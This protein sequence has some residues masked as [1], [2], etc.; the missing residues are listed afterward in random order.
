MVD[1]GSDYWNPLDR[2]PIETLKV[3]IKDLGTSTG[4]GDVLQGFKSD[5]S[6]GA[7]HVELGFTGMAKGSLGQGNTTPEM[8]GKDKRE[9]IRELSKINEVGVTTHA[10]I[11]IN[12]LSGL[13]T[14]N[15]RFSDT[16]ARET[17]NEIKRT[18]DFSA[19]AAGGGAVV[20]HTGEFPRD[21]GEY[22][23]FGSEEVQ[24][25]E[26]V[27]LVDKKTGEIA[28][29]TMNKGEEIYIPELQENANGDWM[30]V[31]GNVTKDR[32]KAIPKVDEEAQIIFK[33]KTWKNYKDEAPKLR[34]KKPKE[35]GNLTND[36]VAAKAMYLD[37]Q[38]SELE[39]AKPFAYQHY[40][41][42]RRVG[43]QIK[44]LQNLQKRYE[45]AEKGGDIKTI[46]NDFKDVAANLRE[47]YNPQTDEN[48]SEF[49]KKVIN[50]S[51]IEAQV[52]LEGYRGYARQIEQ[53]KQ[54]N[55]RIEPISVEG[56]KRSI[57]NITK[58]ATYAIRK[59]EQMERAGKKIDPIY[60]APENIF[61]ESGYG[62][63]PDELKYL[64]VES[65][66]ELANQLHK[67][68]KGKQEATKIAEE[69]IKAT[70]DI[71]H[72]NV[73]RRFFKEDPNKLPEE[74]DK[75]FNKWL[76]GKVD[77]LNKDKI[78]GHAHISDN[79]GYHD[80]HL[81]PGMGSAPINEFIQK[82]KKAGMTEPMIVEW[83]AQSK[84]Q[85]PYGAMLGSWARLASSPIYRI[86]G[87]Q[88]SWTDVEHS[89]YFGRASSPNFIIGKYGPSKDWNA[90]GWSEASI[91]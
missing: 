22:E 38:I 83:G 57:Q 77:E 32:I 89:G 26:I 44:D 29:P 48:P 85:E 24:K 81:T 63:H 60:I 13:D 51:Q 61:P 88:Q 91:E 6:A 8:F 27:I 58:A 5:L 3:S 10:S 47:K 54:L 43:K 36:E 71:G 17:L 19:E 78:I 1:F 59:E 53:I 82:M 64:I 12:N 33:N 30:D 75:A 42:Y 4:A 55:E 86:D 45:W 69:H 23:Q 65:R 70:F 52:Q 46:K 49:L 50:E 84:E 40:D 16:A 7:T 15:G 35:Y 73:W 80:E 72:A 21:I 28:K 87:L 18:V 62:S 76:L 79:F 68:G 34:E 90:W 25:E 66:K 56:K 67:E 2:K 37:K 11:G 9:A 39:R 41:H 14:R 20:V 74:N 31:N